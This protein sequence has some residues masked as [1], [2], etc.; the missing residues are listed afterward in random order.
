MKKII[1]ALLIIMGIVGLI[2]GASTLVQHGI[3]FSAKNN[4]TLMAIVSFVLGIIFFTS[5]IG[6]IKT[7]SD[8]THVTTR[9]RVINDPVAGERTVIKEQDKDQT[10]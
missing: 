1:G 6:L 4:Q 9:E 5:G 2:Y 7:T 10:I 3:D 8:G